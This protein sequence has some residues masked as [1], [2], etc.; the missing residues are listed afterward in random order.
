[1]FEKIKHAVERATKP[2]AHR[3]EEDAE[4]TRAMW[5]YRIKQLRGVLRLCIVL[6]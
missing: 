4:I 1:M 5:D 3:S 6:N 2:S